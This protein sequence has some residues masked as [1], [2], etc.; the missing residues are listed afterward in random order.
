MGDHALVAP[1]LIDAEVAHALRGR[2]LGRK[3]RS[4]VAVELLGVWAGLA[5]ERTPI[6]GLLSRIWE[7]RDNLTAYDAAFV[8][9]AEALDLPLVTADRRLA[10]APGLHCAVQV[11][12]A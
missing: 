9:T 6:T 3:I 10:A 2:A 8:A 7:L 4:D 1:H 5:V 11:P 12:P